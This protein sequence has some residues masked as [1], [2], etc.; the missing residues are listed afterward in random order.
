MNNIVKIIV[1]GSIATLLQRNIGLNPISLEG[2]AFFMVVFVLISFVWQYFFSQKSL[3]TEAAE[4][5]EALKIEKKRN[6]KELFSKVKKAF[7]IV[8]AVIVF[9]ALVNFLSFK[10]GLFDGEFKYRFDTSKAVALKMNENPQTQFQKGA[11]YY[12]LYPYK[13]KFYLVMQKSSKAKPLLLTLYSKIDMSDVYEYLNNEKNF[14]EVLKNISPIVYREVSLKEMVF[15]P[16]WLANSIEH[17]YWTSEEYEKYKS[18]YE[19]EVKNQLF[20]KRNGHL[21]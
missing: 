10:L 13:D 19:Q 11:A 12:F 15:K 4:E 18:Q 17:I 6:Q 20:E 7:L 2:F 5:T 3:E 16:L 21:R 9:N 8:V 14:A 1:A